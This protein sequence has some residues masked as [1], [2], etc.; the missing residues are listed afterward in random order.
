[1]R[2]KIISDTDLSNLLEHLQSVAEENVGMPVVFTLVDS[3]Q[4]WINI[5]VKEAVTQT[6]EENVGYMT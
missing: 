2:T 4:Q 5:N 1:M 3:A 6:E